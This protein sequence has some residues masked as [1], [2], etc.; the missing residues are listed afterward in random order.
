MIILIRHGKA[1]DVNE[2]NGPDNDRPLTEEGKERTK[3]LAK[4]SRFLREKLKNPLLYTSPYL[5]AYQTAAIFGDIWKLEVVKNP[6]FEPGWDGSGLSLDDK[7][8]DIIIVGH[9]PDLK[10][11]LFSLTGGQATI[12]F[13]P[14][15]LA[16]ISFSGD[17]PRLVAYLTWKGVEI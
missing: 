4:G 2:W 16:A 1:V 7:K 5:R 15:S 10:E 9:M 12:E 3:K 11:A 6:L 17:K 13:Q 8:K 14:P